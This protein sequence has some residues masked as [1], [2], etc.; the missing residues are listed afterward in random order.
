MDLIFS[1]ELY[2]VASQESYS[3]AQTSN[4]YAITYLVSNERL[5][6]KE[7]VPKDYQIEAIYPRNCALFIAKEVTKP[8]QLV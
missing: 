5:P 6:T 4:A 2:A 1:K 7:Y 3:F 8:G